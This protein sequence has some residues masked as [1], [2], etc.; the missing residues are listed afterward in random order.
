MLTLSAPCRDEL[1]QAAWAFDPRAVAWRPCVVIGSS[2]VVDGRLLTPVR[3]CEGRVLRVGA[4]GFS[5][6]RPLETWGAR[7]LEE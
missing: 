7:I 4:S 2:E 5:R 1:G 6:E 3:F